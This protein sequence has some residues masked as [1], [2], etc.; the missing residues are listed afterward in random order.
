MEA[1][2]FCWWGGGRGSEDVRD[3]DRCAVGGDVVDWVS[4]MRRTDPLWSSVT[5]MASTEEDGTSASGTDCWVFMIQ[6]CIGYSWSWGTGIYLHLSISNMV[7]FDCWENFEFWKEKP[8]TVVS[9]FLRA[10]LRILQYRQAQKIQSWFRKLQ[11]GMIGGVIMLVA[12]NK[13]IDSEDMLWHIAKNNEEWGT[14]ASE[15]RRRRRR[16]ASQLVVKKPGP[17]PR[18]SLSY[19]F[20]VM[21]QLLLLQRV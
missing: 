3:E 20:R 21:L 2:S 6:M 8:V 17:S 16:R 11:A 9:V 1:P 13:M 4:S 12:W 14:E 7:C 18:Q 5:K 15:E 10:L 19:H